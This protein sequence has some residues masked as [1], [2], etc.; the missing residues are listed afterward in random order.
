MP[1]PW[2]RAARSRRS[3]PD[4]CSGDRRGGGRAR[5]RPR[6]P[7]RGRAAGSRARRAHR[8]RG[9]RAAGALRSTGPRSGCVCLTPRSTSRSTGAMRSAAGRE[10]GASTCVAPSRHRPSS[11][12]RPRVKCRGMMRVA[13]PAVSSTGR[14]QPRA[15]DGSTSSISEDLRGA[16][17]G[18][19]DF[20]V[21]GTELV[22]SGLDLGLGALQRSF[23]V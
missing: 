14:S 7:A 5:R 16:F 9:C 11:R 2:R 1:S 20:L 6:R 23:E 12:A 4:R 8:R 3:L 15:R 22:Q 18:F 19:V 10:R 17:Q 13:S 21:G